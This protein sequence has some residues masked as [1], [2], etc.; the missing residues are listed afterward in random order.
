MKNT[1]PEQRER[2]HLTIRLIPLIRRLIHSSWRNKILYI[3]CSDLVSTTEDKCVICTSNHIQH[4]G[5]F[6]QTILEDKALP[7]I[8]N[9]FDVVII[10]L[11]LI[12]K[13]DHELLLKETY[14][15]LSSTGK[16][17]ICNRNRISF[18][19]FFNLRNKNTR[20]YYSFCRMLRKN[21]FEVLST[22]PLSFIFSTHEN[23]IN[24]KLI[25]Y[26]KRLRKMMP[27]L[28]N[29]HC[30]QVIKSKD[31]YQPLPDY[32]RLSKTITITG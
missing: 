19:H 13:K 12:D 14:R 20:N 24:K 15:V 18:N 31:H 29:Y 11:S 25:R 28:A 30:L 3:H 21:N 4:Q 23:I 22:Y 16:A 6:F 8:D 32:L 5:E 17:L 1:L 10:D 26:E 7:F 9:F 27:A 2:R